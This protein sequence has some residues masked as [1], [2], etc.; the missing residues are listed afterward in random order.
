[1]YGLIICAI[2]DYRKVMLPEIDSFKELNIKVERLYIDDKEFIKNNYLIWFLIIFFVFFLFIVGLLIYIFY[3]KIVLKKQK[4]TLNLMPK[5]N[6]KRYIDLTKNKKF[7][8][9][10][11][12]LNNLLNFSED[13]WELKRQNLK[14]YSNKKLGVGAFGVVYL[15]RLFCITRGCKNSQLNVSIMEANYS[16]VAVKVLPG[17]K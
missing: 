14:I 11:Y 6:E 9:F 12:F 15:G 13:V 1:M 16:D 5:E 4:M 10:F 3:K 17:F 8:F 2:L 7:L